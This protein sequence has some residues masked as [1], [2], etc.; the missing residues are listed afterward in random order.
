MRLLTKKERVWQAKAT[1]IQRVLASKLAVIDEQA[2]QR[3]KRVTEE[4]SLALLELQSQCPHTVKHSGQ[5]R[6]C[7]KEI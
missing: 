2:E 5:C 3:R 7:G 4:A 1:K 6:M